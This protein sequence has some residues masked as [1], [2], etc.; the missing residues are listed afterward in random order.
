MDDAKN[1]KHGSFAEHHLQTLLRRDP[2]KLL[3]E[4]PLVRELPAWR[5]SGGGRKLGRGF[6]DLIGL[7]ANGDITIVETKLGRDDMLVLQGL[8]YWIWATASDNKKSLATRLH[9]S[10]KAEVRLLYAVGGKDG[11]APTLG[12]RERTHLLLLDDDI[13]WRVA[14]IDDWNSPS[15]SVKV[16]DPREV[17]A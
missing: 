11:A 14:L 3:L 5:P 6:I 12:A 15:M 9:T 4:H 13:P 10:D 16:F 8:D 7:D 17:P 2:E 1:K